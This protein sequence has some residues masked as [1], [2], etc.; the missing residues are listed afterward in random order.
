MCTCA[1][2]G[3]A[4]V[5]LTYLPACLPSCLSVCLV[6]NSLFQ[7]LPVNDCTDLHLL[8]GN[9][10]HCRDRRLLQLQ[11][12]L[13]HTLKRS[14]RWSSGQL[15]GQL[16]SRCASGLPAHLM[17]L[18]RRAHPRPDIE[19]SARRPCCTGLVVHA[20]RPLLCIMYCQ[21]SIMCHH[22]CIMCKLIDH[23]ASNSLA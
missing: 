9:T 10:M 20:H 23:L 8:K 12:R 2:P 11:R 3:L 19:A 14:R 16:S 7:S 21:V 17:S 4:R 5:C 15:G 6:H 18:R 13:L 22:V 1:I